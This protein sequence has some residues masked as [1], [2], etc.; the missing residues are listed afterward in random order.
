MNP[1]QMNPGSLFEMSGYYWKT[2]TLHAAVKLDLFTAVGTRQLAADDV[3]GCIHG[4]PRAVTLLLN[5]L[6]AMELLEKTG[7]LFANTPVA[8]EFLSKD[9]KRYIGYMIMHHHYLVQSWEQLDV[10]VKTGRPTRGDAAFGDEE[11]RESFLMGMFNNAMV[12]APRVA[13]DIDLGGKKKLLDLG[14]GPG[15][16][17]IHFCMANPELE[18]TVFDLPTTRPFMEKTVARFNQTDRIDFQSGSYLTDEI[19]GRYDAAWLSH[20]LHGEGPEDCLSIIEKA[21]A[22]LEPG[23]CI[24]IHDFI[25]ENSMDGPLFPALFALNM[26][27]G[28]PSGQTYSQAQLEEMLEKAGARHIKRLP[29]KGPTESGILVATI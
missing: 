3:A 2:C 24:M 25:L 1:P 11:R 16:Y 12:I 13:G 14:G 27:L 5:A 9:S 8:L 28:T 10:A 21:V 23:G 15:T 22:V 26:L 20:I 6:V 18:A 17:A 4:D 19:P 7:D 29:F